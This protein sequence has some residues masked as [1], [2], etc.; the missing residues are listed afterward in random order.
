[1]TCLIK[2]VR[3]ADTNLTKWDLT[4]RLRHS[5]DSKGNKEPDIDLNFSNEYQSK[6]HSFTEVILEKDRHLKREQSVRFAEKT[7]YGYVFNYFKDKSEKKRAYQ[8]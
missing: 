8:S 4:F 1:M 2:Y 3:D 7:A 5:L 6:A